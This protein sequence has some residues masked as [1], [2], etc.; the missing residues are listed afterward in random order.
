MHMPGAVAGD[1]KM[2][3]V[4]SHMRSVPVAAV[5]SE[6]IGRLAAKFHR[7]GVRHIPVIDERGTL[8]G[9]A[10]AHI[11]DAYGT[12]R[13]DDEVPWVQDEPGLTGLTAGDLAQPWPLVVDPDAPLAQVLLE[14]ASST[15][16][17]TVAIDR[18]GTPI[19]ILDEVDAVRMAAT[20]LPPTLTVDEHGTTPV[21][22]L[23]K[24]AALAHAAEV[25]RAE[26]VRHMVVLD[27][28][29]LV[30]VLSYRDLSRVYRTR[31]PT[32]RVED[33]LPDVPVHS[34]PVGTPLRSAAHT[35]A[36]HRVGSIPVID[37]A[38]QP[39]RIVT[40]TDVIEVL[41]RR[42][43]HPRTHVSGAWIL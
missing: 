25:M 6:H 5:R 39:I 12:Y 18:H 31:D 11:L 21:L 41:A 13:D 16:D 28:G 10:E 8:I 29:R 37:R 32:P 36:R 14:L 9:V 27:G 43:R 24:R 33:A 22:G 1:S 3:T 19:G 15:F 4:S 23:D 38:G 40:R 30:G 17:A 35:M 7:Y 20:A 26:G 2:P 34:A 42:L